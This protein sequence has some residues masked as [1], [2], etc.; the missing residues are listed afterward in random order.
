MAG[1]KFD[2]SKFEVVESKKFE[3][4][5]VAKL[6]YTGG[7]D[8]FEEALKANEITEKAYRAAKA[9]EKEYTE[10]AI[11]TAEEVAEKHLK[12]HK[13]LKG[14][15]VELPLNFN[16]KI[17]A[18]ATREVEFHNPQNPGETGVTSGFNVRVTDHM[19]TSKSYVKGLKEK[20]TAALITK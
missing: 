11:A 9:V 13:S 10:A 3:D 18:I 5:G 1:I 19:V 2:L 15:V 12:K 20:L 4:R 14:A 16:G 6:K 7:S 17:E 8:V